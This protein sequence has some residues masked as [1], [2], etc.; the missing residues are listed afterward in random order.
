MGGWAV[1]EGCHEAA[2]AGR[3]SAAAGRPVAVWVRGV[4]DLPCAFLLLA[5][6]RT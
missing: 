6:R 5:G 3:V 4:D 2:V 1:T